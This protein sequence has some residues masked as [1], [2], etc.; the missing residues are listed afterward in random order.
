MSLLFVVEA[1]SIR[2]GTLQDQT[3]KHFW[4]NSPYLKPRIGI[5]EVKKTSQSSSNIPTSHQNTQ[6]TTRVS[7]KQMS[8]QKLPKLSF[9][10]DRYHSTSLEN[11]N[12]FPPV[13]NRWKPLTPI[14][15][16]LSTAIQN[17]IEQVEEQRFERYSKIREQTPIRYEKMKADLSEFAGGILLS[18]IANSFGDDATSL[19]NSLNTSSFD[20]SLSQAITLSKRNPVSSTPNCAPKSN[21]L[22]PS[23]AEPKEITRTKPPPDLSRTPSPIL[24]TSSLHLAQQSPPPLVNSLPTVIMTTPVFLP[25][26]PDIDGAISEMSPIPLQELNVDEDLEVLFSKLKGDSVIQQ[27]QQ[28]HSTVS[29]LPGKESFSFFAQ[30]EK[31]KETLSSSRRSLAL[32][33]LDQLQADLLTNELI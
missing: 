7:T 17:K 15:P 3:T 14:D 2:T 26:T 13:K 1:R 8:Q 11:L 10:S 23:Q 18:E 33:Y 22:T 29:K 21:H 27:S 16:T 31:I 32:Q 6:T 25:D 19:L 24:D 12:K 30:V 20:A 4:L 28:D 5:T 9:F